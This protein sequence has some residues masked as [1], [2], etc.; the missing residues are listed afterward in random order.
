MVQGEG[1]IEAAA[2]S[3][4]I[5]QSCSGVVWCGVVCGGV[6]CEVC[7]MWCGIVW[8]GVVWCGVVWCGVVWCGGVWCVV[9]C[10]VC[11]VWCG[12]VLTWDLGE[13]EGVVAGI[14]VGPATRFGPCL[15]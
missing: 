9:W 14:T 2:R 4:C 10:V 1:S 15:T 11:G 8:C 12:M 6:W 13:G 3:R 7:G 5:M